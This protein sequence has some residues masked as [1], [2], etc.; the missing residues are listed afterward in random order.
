MSIRTSLLRFNVVI[1]KL[2]R[3]PLNFDEIKNQLEIESEILGEDLTI[4]KRT[5][6]RD[7]DTIRSLY[8]I[9]ILYDRSQQVYRID[10]SEAPE[11]HELILEAFDTLNALDI[12]SRIA[13]YIHF[14]KRKPK[15]T[16]HLRDLLNAVRQHVEVKFIYHKFWE[17]IFTNRHVKPYA[18]KEFRNRWYLMALDDQKIKSFALDRMSELEVLKKKFSYPDDFDV[19]EYYENC[20]GI[21]APNAPQPEEVIL[22]FNAFQGKYIKSLPLHSTQEVITDTENEFR[23]KLKIFLTHDFFME[24]L[25]YGE[26]VKVIQ[27]KSLK[28]K[29]KKTAQK[30]VAAHE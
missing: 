9:N 25:S 16:V 26:N 21:V 20:F 6:Q 4:S 22:S 2:R 7:I 23:I 5:F 3:S 29:L 11:A 13:Q 19:N 27:P 14:E 24:L 18:L 30:M 10:S 17:N 8:N 28:D 1:N 12:S 15:G